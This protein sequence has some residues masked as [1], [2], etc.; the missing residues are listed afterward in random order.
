MGGNGSSGSVFA[1]PTS[2]RQA[3]DLARDTPAVD[4]QV[5]Q[6]LERALTEVWQRV[7]AQPD[8][9]V[10]TELEFAVFNYHRARFE[11]SEVAAAA[12]DRFWRHYN[13]RH[14]GVNGP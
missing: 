3:L 1:N 7:Q 14:P 2:I 11:G 12:V 5:G 6:L 9:Y 4:A 10:F 13:R 8:S